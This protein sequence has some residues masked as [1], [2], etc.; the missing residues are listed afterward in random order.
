MPPSHGFRG[1]AAIKAGAKKRWLAGCGR[2]TKKPLE[3]AFYCLQLIETPRKLRLLRRE[4]MKKLLALA[5]LAVGLLAGCASPNYYQ[6]TGYPTGGAIASESECVYVE[7][8]VTATGETVPASYKCVAPSP[9]KYASGGCSW[10]SSYYR[11]DGTYVSGHTRCTDRPTIAAPSY[12]PSATGST[13]GPV[14]VRGYY[15]KDGTYVR[16][17]TRSRSSSRRR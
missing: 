2:A 1:L 11:Q 4:I 12:Y 15:R 10:V 14:N 5:F 8:H 7:S 9:T 13:G 6:S 17:H 3:G 16:P